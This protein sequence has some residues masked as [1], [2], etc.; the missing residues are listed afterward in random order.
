MTEPSQLLND[1]KRKVLVRIKGSHS[2]FLV[3]PNLRLNFRAMRV[4]VSPRIDKVLRAQRWIALEDVR[5]G[6]SLPA[7]LLECPDGDPSSNNAWFA[8]ADA[9]VSLDSENRADG[10]RRIFCSRDAKG[11]HDATRSLRRLADAGLATIQSITFRRSSAGSDSSSR[12]SSFT[13][14]ISES[15]IAVR[16]RHCRAE[17]FRTLLYSTAPAR[18]TDSQGQTTPFTR[19]TALLRSNQAIQIPLQIRVPVA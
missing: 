12:K 5:L 13:V 14:D 19:S 9:R 1:G 2:C 8:A 3:L 15:R 17:R 6:D 10:S 16:R 7:H 11:I 4:N 18:R